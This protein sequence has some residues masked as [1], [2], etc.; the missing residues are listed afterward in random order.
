MHIEM[1]I[2]FSEDNYHVSFL[3]E[4]EIICPPGGKQLDGHPPGGKQQSILGARR[5]DGKEWGNM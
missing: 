2:L 4:L 5:R 3:L 1:Y